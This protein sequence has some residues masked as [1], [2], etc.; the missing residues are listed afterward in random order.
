MHFLRFPCG[1]FFRRVLMQQ[2]VQNNG[3]RR[4]VIQGGIFKSTCCYHRANEPI[5]R[6]K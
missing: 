6:A 5:E 3:E 2:D 1:S 4:C